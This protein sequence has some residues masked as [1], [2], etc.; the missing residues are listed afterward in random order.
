MEKAHN[1]PDYMALYPDAVLAY[2]ASDM[3]RSIAQILNISYP[4]QE[5]LI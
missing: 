5:A 3:V 1:F 4:W 2:K